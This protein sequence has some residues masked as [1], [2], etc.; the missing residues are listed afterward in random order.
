MKIM[1]FTPN[2]GYGGASKMLVDIA[3]SLSACDN[4][5]YI[6]TY[7]NNDVLQALDE[8]II[9]VFTPL[10][11]TTNYFFDLYMKTLNLRKYIKENDFDLAISFL[12]PAKSILSVACLGL[13]TKVLVS[14]RGDP[15][16]CKSI[17]R[18]IEH[19]VFSIF[20]D[21]YVFQ[22]EMAKSFY[23]KRVRERS[24][25][26]NNSL[27]IHDYI[28]C[29]SYEKKPDI[30]TILNVGRLD[31]PLKRQDLLLHAFSIVLKEY[32]STLLK[33]QGTGD[34]KAILMK[35]VLDLGIEDNV[36]FLGYSN[37]I[38]EEIL[39]S[40]IFCLSSDHE[41]I[42]N[43]LLEALSVGIPC[44]STDCAPG[45]ARI[46]IEDKVNGL[47]VERG[48]AQALADAIK[49]YIEHPAERERHG[50]NGVASVGKFAPD[51][52]HEQWINFI[53]SMKT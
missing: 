6:L 38:Y 17:K 7:K 52:I 36:V 20:P 13:N 39:Q 37:N 34:D 50:R 23:P 4:E 53:M 30:T 2:I 40:D 47:L 29:Y 46:L 32:P 41:G 14:E 12:G 51:L 11:Q 5:V 35:K 49:Y 3:N 42:P 33:F 22:T 18:K 21:N 8:R 25:V 26:I 9:H 1:F 16:V 45:G 27:P 44:I 31:I 24:V 19:A 15:S 28:G 48:N 43:A 10:Y